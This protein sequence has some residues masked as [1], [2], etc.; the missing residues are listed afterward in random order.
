[1]LT[2][3]PPMIY[4]TQGEHANHY[5]TND[6]P[7]KVSTL[8]ITSPKIYHTQGEHAN[9][10]TTNDLPRGVMVSMLILS[11]VDHWWCNG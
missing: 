3:T 4:H 10:H 5:T 11:V 8:T 7:L 6:L 9:H 1:M 2:I